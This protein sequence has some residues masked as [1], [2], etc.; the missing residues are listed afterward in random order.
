MGV[1]KGTLSTPPPV[2]R[3]LPPPFCISPTTL[4]CLFPNFATFSRKFMIMK[5]LSYLT[6]GYPYP[7]GWEAIYMQLRWLLQHTWDQAEACA[8]HTEAWVPNYYVP[9][10]AIYLH[11]ALCMCVCPSV[12]NTFLE[13]CVNSVPNTWSTHS[14]KRRPLRWTSSKRQIK[15]KEKKLTKK[16]II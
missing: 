3:P 15:E 10:H 11:K 14:W 12:R 4:L 13:R 16:N 1:V 8:L 6:V 9:P 7:C 5:L 2:W